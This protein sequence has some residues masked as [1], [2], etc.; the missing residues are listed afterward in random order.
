MDT[1]AFCNDTLQSRLF[2]CSV[3]D[4]EYAELLDVEVR[5]HKS[6]V[7]TVGY[8]CCY[9]SYRSVSP[10]SLQHDN[11]QLSDYLVIHSSFI[12]AKNL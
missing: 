7:C 9:V 3:T 11:R 2:D 4:E 5:S 12:V 10:W 6:S 1:T 8:P